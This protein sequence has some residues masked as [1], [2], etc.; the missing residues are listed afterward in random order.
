MSLHVQ[1]RL[2]ALKQSCL[3]ERLE[4]FNHYVRLVSGFAI[5]KPWHIDIIALPE[6]NTFIS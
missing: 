2:N 6:F 3:S 1:M 5:S 4:T